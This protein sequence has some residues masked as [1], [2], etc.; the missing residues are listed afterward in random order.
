MR[1]RVLLMAMALLSASL[2][3]AAQTGGLSGSVSATNQLE[4]SYSTESQQ[5][6]FE[7]WLDVSYYLDGFRTGL[8][9]NSRQPSEEGQRT[10]EIAH[11]F[12]EFSSGD[13]DVRAGHFYGMFGRG[14]IFSAYEDRIVRV[15]TALDG[16]LFSTRKGRFQGTAF[17]GS[18]SA[19]EIDVRGMDVEYDLGAGWQ[20]GWTGLTY[21]AP[22][23]PNKINREWVTGV[24]LQ[25]YMD[26]SDFYLEYAWKQGYDY[27]SSLDEE[28]Q[29]GRAFYA[30]L[31]LYSGS[32]ALALEAKDYDRFSVLKKADGTVSLNNPPALT[33]EHLYT[34]L[35]RNTHNL[36][37]DDEIGGQAELT[38]T[39]PAGW[40]L[41]ASSNRTENHDGA[42][43]FKESY[44]HL[45]KEALGKYR[46]RAAYG[47]QDVTIEQKGIN[48]FI[49]GELTIDLDETRSLTLEVEHQ[50][51]ELGDK[52][53]IEVGP[54]RFEGI[55]HP[56]NFDTQLFIAELA[57]A[58][59][60][61]FAALLEVN[62][63]TL[64]EQL[65]EPGEKEGPFPAGTFSYTTDSG[66]TFTV[67][68]GKR[69]AGQLCVG[70]VCKREPAF[71]GIE[72]Y[73]SFRY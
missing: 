40:S 64:P 6:I 45:E 59:H 12:F 52:L 57:L 26:F 70:G 28:F 38:W 27:Q 44:G 51:T 2:P 58:P 46:L 39:G 67:W 14:L 49:I 3:A 71:E 53:F 66:G 4:Y 33:R 7:N 37:A 35:S 19:L 34:L 56:G 9:L 29:P 60:Y 73:W 1:L 13:F 47:Y 22:A 31:N 65:T 41:V 25:K 63:K 10:T 48:H 24:R 8:L 61:T 54:P 42:V 68:A 16:I 69:Q 18:P 62:N 30:S 50:H 20:G 5:E 23:P 36:N 21:L 11:R 43:L 55:L 15:D 72:C 32:F 17:S